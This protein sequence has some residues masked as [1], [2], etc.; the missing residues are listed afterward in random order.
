MRRNE[1]AIPPERRT[2]PPEHLF[3]MVERMISS[4]V[5]TRR[6]VHL[7]L[8]MAVAAAFLAAQA[9]AREGR[10]DRS[11]GDRGS[12]AIRNSVMAV[13]PAESIALVN[14]KRVVLLTRKGDPNLRFGRDGNLPVPARVAGWSFHPAGVALDSRGRVLLFGWVSPL[15]HRTVA[16]GPYSESVSI[17]RGAT[18]RLL[19]DGRP[20]PDF[21]QGGAVVSDFGVRSELEE[22][23]QPTTAITGGTVD[24][25]DRPLLAVGAA[26]WKG[27][28]HGHSYIGWAPSSLVRLTA[29]GFPDPEFGGGDGLS[30]A[31][32]DFGGTP[33]VSLTLT[34]DDQPLM[35]GA[36]SGGCPEGA[37]VIRLGEE[38]APL[39]G[40]GT[41]GRQDFRNQKFA[42]FTPEGGA[43][44]ERR[45]FGTEI[46]RR[47][48][49]QGQADPS[50]GLDGAVTLRMPPGTDHYPAAA[51][52]SEGRILLVGSE[53][54]PAAG[55]Q[56]KRAFIV[57]ERLLSSGRPDPGFGRHGRITVPVPGAKNVG[58]LQVSLDAAGRL[59]V[60]SDLTRLDENE[61]FTGAAVLTRFLLG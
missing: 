51:V 2:F 33:F 43:I 38:G 1:E 50:F 47:V 26:T 46:V 28:C 7:L 55:P 4:T 16:V 13:G 10:L 20:D 49:P 32:L 11:F 45:R 31:L 14:R 27:S 41:G 42:A 8:G 22:L 25:L 53:S 54:L 52:D 5:M 56:P 36:L 44:L 3:L 29:S 35:G 30:P 61:S 37:S 48:T 6:L 34:S 57:V 40:Y 58:S 23:S 17:S 24:S 21:G 9:Q 60:L 59:L 15:R 18:L 19:P 12:V 39:P